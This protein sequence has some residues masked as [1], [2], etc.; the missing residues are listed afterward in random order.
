MKLYGH[1]PNGEEVFQVTIESSDLQLKVLSLGAIIQDIRMRNVTHSLVLGYPRLEPYFIN[2]GKLGAIVGRYA[3]RI[4][5]GK[6]KIDG[7]IYSFD[8]N[9]NKTHTLHGGTDGSAARNWKIIDYDKSKVKLLDKLPDGHMGFPGNLT[10]ETTYNVNKTSIDIFIEARTD[11]TTLCNFTNHSYFNLDGAKN[12]ANHSLIVNCDTVLPVDTNGIPSSEPVST[13]ELALDFKK[14]RKLNE[15]G[16]PTEIDHNFCISNTR[17]NL[18]TNAIVSAKNISLELLST[19]PGLQIYTGKALDSGSDKG[20]GKFPYKE[21][22]GIALEPQIWPDSPNQS[23]FP[24]PY[25]RP[26][27]RYKHHTRIK[28]YNSNNEK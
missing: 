6:T 4:S 13:K 25:L 27:E 11:K 19:E 18:R 16:K 9:Q 1:M 8:K 14:S 5:H 17:Q 21:F 12:I 26:H 23:S 15:N 3:N 10:V 20:W 24:S 2:L 28:F 22:A 7:K